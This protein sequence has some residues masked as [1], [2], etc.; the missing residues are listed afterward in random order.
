MILKIIHQVVIVVGIVLKIN[1]PC[2]IPSQDFKS[3]T[4]GECDLDG[5]AKKLNIVREEAVAYHN[6]M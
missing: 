1:L 3:V 4:R 5:E 2:D 6:I